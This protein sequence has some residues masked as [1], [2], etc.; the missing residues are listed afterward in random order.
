MTA[1]ETQVLIKGKFP[2]G[3]GG[4]KADGLLSED[5]MLVLKSKTDLFSISVGYWSKTCF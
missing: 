5:E 2:K 3:V 1:P 4:W